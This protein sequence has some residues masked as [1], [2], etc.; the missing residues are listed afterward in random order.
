MTNSVKTS[1][2]ES[3]RSCGCGCGAEVVSGL[4]LFGHFNAARRKAR[5][6]RRDGPRRGDLSPE[7]S[8]VTLDVLEALGA[9]ET[10][11]LREVPLAVEYGVVGI[12]GDEW[13]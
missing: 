1:I 10:R 4:Y 11:D 3:L 13:D 5:R 8:S 6:S 12:Q 7:R 2:Y 9:Q